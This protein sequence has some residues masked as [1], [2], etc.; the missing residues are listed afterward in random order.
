MT[1]PESGS[2]VRSMR[3]SAVRRGDDYVVTGTKHFISH[4]DL[5]D[6]VILFARTGE[7]ISCLLVDIPSRGLEVRKGPPCV[8]HRGYHQCELVFTDCHVPAGNL[9]GE[10]G[11]GFDLMG[12]WLGASRLTVAAAS[13]GR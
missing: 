7:R 8:S 5:A 13:V 2:D 12:E 3:T 11:R 9:L 6:F 4:A 10:E 1:E